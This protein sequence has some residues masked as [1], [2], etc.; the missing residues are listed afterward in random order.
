M[1]ASPVSESTGRIAA[2]ASRF[3]D[4]FVEYGELIE[5]A[6]P[7]RC[8]LVAG[9]P[10]EP[11]IAGY[12]VALRNNS[13]SSD[14]GWFAYTMS[15]PEAQAAAA[16]AVNGLLGSEYRPEDVVMTNAAMA[17]LAV[18]LRA[19]CDAGDEVI[20]VCP[21]HFLYEPIILGTGA[22]AVRVSMREDFDID[23]DGVAAA[24]TERTRAVIVNS[25]HNPTG[26]IYP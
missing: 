23:V 18:T 6:G 21:P 8:D 19:V 7:D 14:P 13:E 11:A 3:F 20:I 24:I 26:R 17:G 10:Q 5:A 2:T 1:T 22:S 4:F 12:G 25:P 16:A 9:N 15:A